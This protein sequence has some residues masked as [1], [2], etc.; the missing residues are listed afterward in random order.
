MK[1]ISEILKVMKKDTKLASIDLL[2]YHKHSIKM[3]D[4][5]IKKL[6]RL[7]KLDDI[8]G[9]FTIMKSYN[10]DRVIITGKEKDLL[11][12]KTILFKY[13][14]TFGIKELIYNIQLNDE[15]NNK[16]VRKKSK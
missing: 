10:R 16:T 5:I 15:R 3:L 1:K 9:T 14:Q 7:V 12:L 8:K 4:Y 11:M 2:F 6:K 13:S